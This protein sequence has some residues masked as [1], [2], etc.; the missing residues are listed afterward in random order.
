MLY[1]CDVKRKMRTYL[2][3]VLLLCLAVQFAPIASLHSHDDHHG[4]CEHTE[5]DHQDDA[6]G[7]DFD[8]ESS[9]DCGLCDV[10][11]ALNDQHLSFDEVA[12]FTIDRHNRSETLSMKDFFSED[13]SNTTR[14]R[15]PP[16]A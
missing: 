5:M 7:S 14:G 2:S 4:C 3:V 12:E 6:Q 1:F 11:L 13:L 10:L 15:A 9:D 8:F 16:T